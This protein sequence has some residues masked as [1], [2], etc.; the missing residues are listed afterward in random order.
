[1]TRGTLRHQFPDVPRGC[2]HP[3]PVEEKDCFFFLTFN[4]V[5]G[6]S[7]LTIAAS[8]GE[9]Q[10]D[11]VIHIHVFILPQPPSQALRRFLDADPAIRLVRI[12][13]HGKQP[14]PGSECVNL[15]HVANLL[16]A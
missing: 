4:F 8:I 15:K 2:C 6:Y 1:M 9:Q 13:V 10:G 5:L 7:W 3:N 12:S 16:P 14:Q 11:S